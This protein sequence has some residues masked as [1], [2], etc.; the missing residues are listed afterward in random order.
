MSADSNALAEY[1][2]P[3]GDDQCGLAARNKEVLLACGL[4]QAIPDIA[5]RNPDAITL[6]IRELGHQRGYSIRRGRNHGRDRA[7]AA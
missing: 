4:A 1:V 3:H 7:Q 6:Y 2:A 5:S